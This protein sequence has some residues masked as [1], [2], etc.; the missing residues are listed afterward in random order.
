[1]PLLYV[2]FSFVYFS[3]IKLGEEASY[4]CITIIG[5]TAWIVETI[6]R[7]NPEYKPL[8]LFTLI[9]DFFKDEY[10]DYKKS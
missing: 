5:C 7:A 3:F 1:M 2:F 10:N 8:N 9:I 4:I 6:K